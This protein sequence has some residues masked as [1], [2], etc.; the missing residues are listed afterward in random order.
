MVKCLQKLFLGD[1]TIPPKDILTTTEQ[2]EDKTKDCNQ[3]MTFGVSRY[4][5]LHCSA[6]RFIVQSGVLILATNNLK[7]DTDKYFGDKH[8][9]ALDYLFFLKWK[10]IKSF[11]HFSDWN[12][13]I[14]SKPVQT[15]HLHLSRSRCSVNTWITE[16][17]T[18]KLSSFYWDRVL[19]TI[20][21]I[22]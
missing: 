8:R 15:S 22:E 4:W 9:C 20:F 2:C 1:Y 6:F 14:L 10:T 17:V 11:N 12:M 18:F 3:I 13:T 19:D 16:K 5:F 21:S 7:V